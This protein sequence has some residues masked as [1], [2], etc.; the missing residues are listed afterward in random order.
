VR[1][2]YGIVVSCPSLFADR[3]AVCTIVVDNWL[4][5]RVKENSYVRSWQSSLS[6]LP[7]TRAPPFN[8]FPLIGRTH[9]FLSACSV[10]A[11]YVVALFRSD[12]YRQGD[13]FFSGKMTTGTSEAVRLTLPASEDGIALG[14]SILLHCIPSVL[15]HIELERRIFTAPWLIAGSWFPTNPLPRQCPAR[16]KG[17]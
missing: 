9:S 1:C 12:C 16:A 13:F 15:R 8:H 17:G 14:T 11:F 2:V 3:A 10:L 5:G 6:H 4:G 7:F